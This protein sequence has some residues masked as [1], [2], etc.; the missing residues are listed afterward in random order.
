MNEIINILK[1]P[2]NDQNL[3]IINDKLISKIDKRIYQ[4]EDGIFKFLNKEIIETKTESV[5]EFYLDYSFPDYNDFDS[6]ENFIIKM[7]N[8]IFIKELLENLKPRDTVLEFGCGTG[9]LGNFLAA[10]G[11]SQ[12]ISADLSIN[13][14]R[15]ANNFK[16]K[17]NIH[18]INF[19]ETDIFNHCFKENIFDVII[20][21]GVL[22]HTADPYLAFQN[23]TKLLKKDGIIILGLYNKISRLKNSLIKYL[24]KVFG[25]K[26]IGIFD[27]IYK[28]K[29]GRAAKAW[30]MDQ[31][32]HP[33]EKRYN[34]TEIHDWFKKNGIEFINSIPSYN[35]EI[36]SFEKV[37][38]IGD[39]MDR[40][41]IEI[42][43][44]IEN[45]EGGLF[46]FIGKKL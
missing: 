1:S 27:K 29:N 36:K 8:N 25:E 42:K 39:R 5:R 31:Y 24:A 43:D 38:N 9:Q 15:L 14:L 3:E 23:L 40:F 12:I 13:S 17:N 46:I 32:F 22:H 30:K 4:V 37:K 35:N 41:N 18:G 2:S 26:A 20:S 10:T 33:L 16:K 6:L 34:F 45:E 19:V 44:L 11:H 21:N 28:N 7:S